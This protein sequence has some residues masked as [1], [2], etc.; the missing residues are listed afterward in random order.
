MIPEPRV[1]FLAEPVLEPI[2]EASQ[3]TRQ[4]I[5][6]TLQIP[7]GKD[8]FRSLRNGESRLFLYGEIAFSD[9]LG[10]DYVQTFCFAYDFPSKGFIQWAGKYN[11]RR[12]AQPSK[13]IRT[14][15]LAC[16]SQR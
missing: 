9:L 8:A 16:R 15:A 3:E 5:T 12:T 10:T 6:K 11:R 4:P 14:H 13:D 7:I 2:I 1:D